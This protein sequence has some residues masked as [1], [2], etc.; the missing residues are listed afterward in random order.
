MLLNYLFL[1]VGRCGIWAAST[2]IITSQA[3]FGFALTIAIFMGKLTI[4]PKMSMF[5]KKPSPDLWPGLAMG[6]SN[7]V[8]Q[9]SQVIPTLLMQ[10]FFFRAARNIGVYDIVSQTWAAT[11]RMNEVIA[12]I[13]NGFTNAFA[14]AASYA[15]GAKRMNRI[16][17]L[18][19]HMLWMATLIAAIVSGALIIWPKQIG[20]IWSSDPDFLYWL[21]QTMPKVF[22]AIT[23][24]PVAFAVPAL[25]AACHL[26]TRSVVLAILILIFPYPIAAG[27]LYW[28]DPNDPARVMYTYM[29]AD[30]F[31]GI[32]GIIGCWK[33]L[34]EC[35]LAP[36]DK[37]AAKKHPEQSSASA[38]SMTWYTEGLLDVA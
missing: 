23:L 9:L 18:L 19:F 33:E 4:H 14:P 25:L 6:L 28:S 3:V 38:T 37:I 8:A 22:Y 13:C 27:L 15:F 17:W 16:F 31:A 12:C 26:I 2:A 32:V 21:S 36:D 34:K 7:L 10:F 24:I 5:V 20:R 11:E 29:V 30:I 1:Y 35:W